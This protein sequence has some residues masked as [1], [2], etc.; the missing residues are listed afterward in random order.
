[1]IWVLLLLQFLVDILPFW[2][3]IRIYL[4]I[5]TLEVKMLRIRKLSTENFN[6]ISYLVIL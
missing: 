5:R 1:M 6:N 4:R 2:I 3:R